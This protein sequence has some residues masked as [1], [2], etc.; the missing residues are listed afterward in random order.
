MR[1]SIVV[2]ICGTA[3]CWKVAEDSDPPELTR[4]RSVSLEVQGDAKNGFHLIMSPSGCFTA[5]TW[6]ATLGD[7]FDVAYRAFGVRPESWSEV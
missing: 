6:H 1:N 4:E 7:A 5:D 2:R 3:N